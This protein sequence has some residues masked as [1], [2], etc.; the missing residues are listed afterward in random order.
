MALMDAATT[1]GRKPKRVD[2]MDP[3][4]CVGLDASVPAGLVACIDQQIDAGRFKSRSHFLRRLLAS[5]FKRPELAGTI[6]GG[7]RPKVEPTTAA[8]TDA[9]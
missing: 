6:R 9:R 1:R 2:E 4:K 3:Q 7:R 5:Y 8:E